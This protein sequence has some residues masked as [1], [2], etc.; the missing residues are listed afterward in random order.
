MSIVDTGEDP[1]GEDMTRTSSRLAR[2]AALLLAALL[3]A[4]LA[5]LHAPAGSLMAP[6]PAAADG[7]GHSLNIYHQRADTD[8]LMVCKDWTSSSSVTS[9]CSSRFASLRP[10][11]STR[12]ALGWDDTDGARIPKGKALKIDNVGPN[13]TIYRNC[14]SG[15]KWKKLSPYVWNG[16]ATY[17]LYIVNANC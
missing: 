17:T 11:D 6:A 2:S 13:L 1:E 3:L 12:G 5:T 10:G 4:L 8:V 16:S 14:T 7:T 15:T 9:S